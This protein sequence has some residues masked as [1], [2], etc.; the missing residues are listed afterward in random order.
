[1]ASHGGHS[2]DWVCLTHIL[3]F[4]LGCLCPSSCPFHLCLHLL[5]PSL[6]TCV[7]RARSPNWSALF[8]LATFLIKK[9]ISL[10]SERPPRRGIAGP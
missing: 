9:L 1:M 8:P 4:H 6:P 2:R 3:W 10:P 7:A 5:S